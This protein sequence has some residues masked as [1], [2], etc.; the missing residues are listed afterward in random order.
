MSTIKFGEGSESG[1]QT[2]VWGPVGW[3]FLHCIV[4]N[5]PWNPTPRQKSEYK[6]FLSA[7]ASVLP[8]RYCR[9]SFAQYISEKDT[10]LNDKSL[11]NRKT[12]TFWLYKMHNKVNRKLGVPPSHWPSFEAVWKRYESYRAKCTKTVENENKKGCITPL[13]GKK[14][15]CVLNIVSV[16]PDGNQRQSTS[17]FGIKG[18]FKTVLKAPGRM[19]KPYSLKLDS[20]LLDGLISTT[21]RDIVDRN[22][23]ITEAKS[24]LRELNAMK[25]NVGP[26]RKEDYYEMHLAEQTL[27]KYINQ[28]KNL[29]KQLRGITSGLRERKRLTNIQRAVYKRDTLM[30]RLTGRSYRVKMPGDNRK[31]NK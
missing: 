13:H 31:K 9:E 14:K 11:K 18:V 4:Q 21:N 17:S 7:I 3:V 28:Q 25:K 24:Q 15:K 29:V 26:F 5:Y 20:K 23:L 30:D 8:C 27:K 1:M 22:K 6:K 2:K 10:L 16:Q 12:L 19:I